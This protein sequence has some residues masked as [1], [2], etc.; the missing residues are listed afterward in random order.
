MAVAFIESSI[1]NETPPEVFATSARTMVP[2][3]VLAALRS[4][5]FDQFVALAK[6]DGS[7]VILTQRGRN[8]FRHVQR[9]LMGGGDSEAATEAVASELVT[10]ALA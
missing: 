4:M 6:P 9:A 7:S 3:S 10:E 1:T 8:F 5:P 2:E